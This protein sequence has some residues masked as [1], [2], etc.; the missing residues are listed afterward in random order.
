MKIILSRKGFDSSSGGGPSP[1]FPDGRMLSLPIPD[2][3]SEIRYR[4]IKWEDRNLGK[5]VSELTNRRVSDSH[6]AHLDPD[7]CR[8]SLPR[9]DNWLPVFG[10]TGAAQ[11]HLR[12]QNVTVGDVFLFFGLFRDVVFESEHL[13]WRTGS[14]PRHVIW[15][16]LQVGEIFAVDELDKRKYSWAKDHPHLNRPP[17]RNNTMYIAK[18][19]LELPDLPTHQRGS[20]VFPRFSEELQLTASDAASTSVWELPKWF[21]PVEGRQPLSYHRN[22][23]SWERKPN[24]TRLKVVARGQEFI[25]ECADYPEATKWLYSLIAGL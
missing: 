8:E 16:W 17:D 5:I 20:G 11:G 2:K 14:K 19:I 24:T 12:N 6:F 7:L 18:E 10:Q 23:K 1:I 25:L 13:R 15:G 9:A 22:L 21:F 3:G 4:D